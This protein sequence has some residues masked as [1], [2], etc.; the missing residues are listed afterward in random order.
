MK[1]IIISVISLLFS[2]Q[3]VVNSKART[4]LTQQLDTIYGENFQID[5]L[6]SIDTHY[7][8]LDEMKRLQKWDTKLV[9]DS[10]AIASWINFYKTFDDKQNQSIYDNFNRAVTEEINE[11]RRKI[12]SVSLLIGT[13]GEE[14]LV[15]RIYSVS[16][17]SSGEV[18]NPIQVTLDN[19]LGYHNYKITKIKK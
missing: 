12:D 10:I 13:P 3:H 15:E 8:T 5:E 9:Y 6:L 18:T 16:V 4:A 7:V 14:I 19:N 2:C 17:T 11:N 1:L